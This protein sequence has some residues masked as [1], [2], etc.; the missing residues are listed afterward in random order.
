M[1]LSR[2]L[3]LKV[4]RDF[5]NLGDLILDRTLI[6]RLRPFGKLI[7]NTSGVPHWYSSAMGLSDTELVL[8]S[9][10]PI[11]LYACFAAIRNLRRRGAVIYLFLPPG[12]SYTHSHFHS[13]WTL[14]KLP[15]FGVLRILNVQICRL[16]YSI[17]SFDHLRSF[18]E[19]VMSRLMTFY[20][21][22]DSL[23]WH[24]AT[25][26]GVQSPKHFPD[27]SLL[28][29]FS[30]GR[31]K[32][33]GFRAV[34]SFRRTPLSRV[35]DPSYTRSLG[36]TVELLLEFC[37][38]HKYNVSLYTHGE[39]DRFFAEELRV[40]L[41][42]NYQLSPPTQVQAK[43]LPSVYTK[44]DLV[45]TN[46]LHVFLLAILH[47]SVAIAAID[48]EKQAK[49]SGIIA[50]LG[51]WMLTVDISKSDLQSVATMVNVAVAN[52]ERWLDLA[53]NRIA[54][55]RCLAD[56]S[57]SRL[58]ESPQLTI[59]PGRRSATYQEMNS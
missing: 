15:A 38:R 7:L 28:G 44:I 21:V 50:D 6:A 41:K 18:T 32:K 26:I 17:S 5:D 8:N 43:H 24:Y 13:F 39:D 53:Y 37:R 36:R 10:I 2:L 23:S 58:M 40:Q 55:S 4:R 9:S 22:R 57:L 48:P 49:I 47:G 11:E 3:F 25:S 19:R 1:Y 12:H 52:K 46:R 14:L 20:S 27:L 45:F 56:D 33:D 54:A 59:V 30:P 51:L 35:P 29:D 34:L 31:F 42:Q 16:G